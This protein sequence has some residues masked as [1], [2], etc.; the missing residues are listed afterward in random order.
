MVL[1]A[2][3]E[4][5]RAGGSLSRGDPSQGSGFRQELP[6]RC[7]SLTPAKQILPLRQAQGQ[8]FACR[9]RTARKTAQNKTGAYSPPR[10]S[11]PA[12]KALPKPGEPGRSSTS[13]QLVRR[14]EAGVQKQ[15]G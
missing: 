8:D 5:T 7:A 4:I 1:H 12:L 3:E 15:N 2:K 11:A 13:G 14:A 6:L 9:A 10:F